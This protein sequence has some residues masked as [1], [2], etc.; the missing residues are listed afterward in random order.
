MCVLSFDNLNMALQ[1][2]QLTMNN[3]NKTNNTEIDKKIIDN[4]AY[5]LRTYLCKQDNITCNAKQAI[6]TVSMGSNQSDYKKIKIRLGIPDKIYNNSIQS[7]RL[8]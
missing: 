6:I 4:I 2:V 8:I 1:L 7:N 5:Y 3:L